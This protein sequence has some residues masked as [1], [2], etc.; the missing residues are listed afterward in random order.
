MQMALSMQ[1]ILGQIDD[2]HDTPGF[3]ADDLRCGLFEPMDNLGTRP[4]N[5]RTD[6]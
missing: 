1:P 3:V 2:G 4:G 5:G 6:R